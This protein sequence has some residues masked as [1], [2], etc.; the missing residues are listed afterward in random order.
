MG[1]ADYLEEHPDLGRLFNSYNWGGYVIWRLYPQYLSFVD[2]R[3][4]L[5][6][7]VILDDYLQAWRAEEGWEQ[8]MLEWDIDVALIEPGAPLAG[9]LED[10]GW[11]A[12]Y[13]DSKA[14]I[15]VR[16]EP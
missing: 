16:A 11:E 4:D 7:D 1:A 13:A 10:A 8:I 5:F 6:D 3:T 12:A 14:V 15:L 9:A 2:G